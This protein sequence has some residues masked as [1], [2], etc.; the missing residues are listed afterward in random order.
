MPTCAPAPRGTATWQGI[1]MNQC[2]AV[3]IEDSEAT[4]AD[5]NALDFVAVQYGHITGSSFHDGNWC[6][7]L[8]VSG[9]WE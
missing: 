5:N 9:A 2:A 4:G 7:Y 8:K 1:K 6:F 3:F